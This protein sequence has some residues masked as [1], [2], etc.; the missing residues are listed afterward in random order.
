MPLQMG[1]GREEQRDRGERGERDVEGQRER[2]RRK[3]KAGKP[4]VRKE[5]PQ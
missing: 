4:P 5:A 1:G 2:R 3:E